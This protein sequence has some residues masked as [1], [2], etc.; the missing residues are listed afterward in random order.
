MDERHPQLLRSIRRFLVWAL[1]LTGLVAVAAATMIRVPRL[2]RE[3]NVYRMWTCRRCGSTRTTR[4][5]LWPEELMGYTSP[6]AK[7]CL[8]DWQTGISSAV[9]ARDGQIILLRKDGIYGALVLK[10]QNDYRTLRY[11]WYYRDD[12]GGRFAESTSSGVKKGEG[13]GAPISFGPFTVAWSENRNG[14]G[15]LYY[16]CAPGGL[17]A[18]GI[19]GMCLTEETD[20]GNVDA[21]DPK[22]KYKVSPTDPGS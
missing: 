15:W 20:I 12:S 14:W 2:L 1:L 13:S 9:N 5:T 17:P 22:W 11:A 3:R 8:H 6:E 21:T 16:E 4:G 18:Q 7:S 10:G 19:T